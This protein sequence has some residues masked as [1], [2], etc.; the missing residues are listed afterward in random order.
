MGGQILKSGGCSYVQVCSVSDLKGKYYKQTFNINEQGFSRLKIELLKT[1]QLLLGPPE[2]SCN[3]LVIIIR[4][5]CF[6]TSMSE[7][8]N[9]PK[10]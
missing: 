7:L 5:S 2:K 9:L 6:S 4:L 8:Y 1:S 3:I 10:S